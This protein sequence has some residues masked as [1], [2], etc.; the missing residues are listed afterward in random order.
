MRIAS[1]HVHP[2]KA[3]RAI[4]VPRAELRLVGLRHDRR[5]MVVD[6]DARFLTQRS[7]PT[8]ALV[9]TAIDGDALELRTP[10]GARV[11]VPLERADGP[12]RRAIVWDDE[13]ACV[14][15]S[16]EASAFFSDH[17]GAPASL[18]FMPADVVRAVERPYGRDGDRVGLADAYPVLLASLASL[19]D[20]EARVGAA[21][22]MSRFRPNLVVD[23]GV[24]WDE[25]R[26]GTARVGDV[27][28]RM[29]K[30]CSRCEVTLVD[31]RT[32][33]KG[34]EPLRTLATF[35]AS[36]NKVYFAMNCIPDGEGVV[37]VGDPVSF[38]EPRDAA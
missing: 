37:A 3:C 20:V 9:E 38:G 19:A 31:Q 4:D 23:G 36:G 15:P 1:I 6:A 14:E 27:S 13:V 28:L 5:Y 17:L 30:R 10:N 25:E 33:A 7:H 11:R 8:L 16:A 32:A 12:R 24:A 18:V 29:P 22:P 34:K 35:R 2:V 26:H 21:V